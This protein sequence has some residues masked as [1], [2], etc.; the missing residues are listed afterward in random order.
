MRNKTVIRLLV[1]EG[2]EDAVDL[3]LGHSMGDGQRWGS[4]GCSI[5]AI[6]LP[7]LFLTVLEAVAR[8]LRE[9]TDGGEADRG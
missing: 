5:I 4:I 6:T 8:Q 9:A 7:T 3:Q 2:P 1:Y